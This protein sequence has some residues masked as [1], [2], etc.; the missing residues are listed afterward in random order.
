M[1]SH[2]AFS[3]ISDDNYLLRLNYGNSP[4]IRNAGRMYLF[5]S[6]SIYGGSANVSKQFRLISRHKS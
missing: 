5:M 4:E 6:D 2:L 3:T 1:Y